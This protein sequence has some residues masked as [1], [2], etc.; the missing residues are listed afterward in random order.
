MCSS[1]LSHHDSRDPEPRSDSLKNDVTRYLKETITEKENT[2][3]ETKH[4]RAKAEI[5]IHLQARETDIHPVQP[6]DNIKHKEKW[7]QPPRH[8]AQRNRRQLVRV[9]C[10][11]SIRN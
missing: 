5:S 9:R 6:S 8:F 3:T 2:G 1:D 10:R 11:E 7:N 4:C